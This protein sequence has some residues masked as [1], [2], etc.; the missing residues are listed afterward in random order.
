MSRKKADEKGSHPSITTDLNPRRSGVA[1]GLKKTKNISALILEAQ[2]K[3]KLP[4]L[5]E[6]SRDSLGLE[7]ARNADVSLAEHTGWSLVH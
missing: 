7:D 5:V 6:H 2:T 3:H 4:G 1:H